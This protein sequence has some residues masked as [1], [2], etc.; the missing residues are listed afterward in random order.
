MNLTT[1]Q[2]EE[3]STFVVPKADLTRFA[4]LPDDVRRTV[5]TLLGVM[6][7][8]AAS[9]RV[10][11]ACEE[12]ARQFFGRRG[13]SA[14]S[15]RRK[16]Y[17]FQLEGWTALIDHSAAGGVREA[18][19][20]V[21]FVDWFK[22]L[23]ERNQRKTRPAWR[24]FKHAWH[25]GARVPGLD[26]S[27]RRD[28]LP[29]GCS[30]ANLS[31][32]VADA[33]ALAA[34]RR[35]LGVARA[36]H[37]PQ[38]L[39]TRAGLWPMSHVMIDDMW[40]DNFVIFRG[41]PVR[42]L[43]FDAIDVL[44]G[45]KIGWGTKPRLPR[46]DGTMEG[47]QEKF[48][49]ML[50]AQVFFQHGYHPT[51]G[52]TLMAEHGT[53]AVREDLE[54]ILHDRTGGKITVRR[55]GIV[56]REQAVRGMFP[57]R[58][59]GN[60]RFKSPLESLRGLIHNELAALPGQT[61]LDYTHLPETTAGEV[62]AN[63]ELL[64]AVAVL[65]QTNPDRAALLQLSLLQYH[66]QFLPLLGDVYETINRRNWHE[67]E[68]WHACGFVVPELNDA[69]QWVAPEALPPAKREA[70]LA[71]ARI[72]RGYSREIRLSPRQVFTR[73]AGQLER[74][75]AFVV[76]EILGNDFAREERCAN[77][78][79]EFADSEIAPEP[80]R[81]ESRI[82]D[83]EGNERELPADKYQVFVNPFDLN[84]LFIHDA[85]GRHLGI[86]RRAARV[87]RADADG[88]LRQFGHNNAR[89][90][91][92]LKPIRARHA[93]IT[94]DASARAAHNADVIAGTRPLTDAEKE[95]ARLVRTEGKTAAA[96]ILASNP[97]PEPDTDGGDS[98]LAALRG[99]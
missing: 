49:R 80:L 36:A 85:R 37:G 95:S 77:S 96:D 9:G 65:A 66:S 76:A 88:L 97:E 60:P 69:G 79:F 24:T 3:V 58:G 63:Q 17:A 74:I 18:A 67:L 11:P 57:G 70:L 32:K 41:V 38:I 42:V 39:T 54:R 8:I 62:R 92:L 59:G 73:G 71:L 61:G 52:T 43:E 26:N 14:A 46:E 23:A 55:S 45:C 16:W 2:P 31:R 4:T 83:P 90:A 44:S 1:T 68:G 30:Y 99:E 48:V 40:H 89:L 13:F 51:Q 15:L 91:D 35:G 84:Q 87:S 50:M 56:G 72:D 28:Q 22:A 75:P 94:R 6:R 21:E 10:N 34:M 5:Q 98:F 82:T 33:F 19:L 47:L 29:A 86:A 20:P 25:S 53:A 64:K 78:Y 27:A 81:F 93:D 7:G 12:Q